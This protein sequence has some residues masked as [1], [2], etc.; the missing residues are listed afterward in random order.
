MKV[1]KLILLVSVIIIYSSWLPSAQANT[2]GDIENHWA[3]REIETV[4]KL[5]I[6][7]NYPDGAFKP[8]QLI[9]RAEFIKLLVIAG[10]IKPSDQKAQPVFKD[11]GP[12]FWA[13]SYVEA[14]VDAG[15]LTIAG[16]NERFFEPNRAITRT[17]MA[18]QVG[19]LMAA[20]QLQGVR[21][22]TDYPPISWLDV[23][24]AKGII[25]GYPD[26][27]LA[28]SRGLT[29][30]EACVVILRLKE[31]LL[32]GQAKRERQWISRMQSKDGY[33]T[34]AGGRQDVNP[35]FGNLTLVAQLGQP[36]YW[37]E[38]K[39]YLEW[40]LAHL[41]YPDNLGLNGTIYNFRLIDG[42][43]Q[44][45]NTYDSADSYA[46]T[47]LSLAAAYY[48][49]SGD[50][51]FIREHFQE[52]TT[53]S[54][55]ITTLQDT[56]GLIWVKPDTKFKYLMDN[57]ECY[58]G[59]ADWSSLLASLG[60][61]DQSELCGGKA[62]LIK[63]GILERF[64]DEDTA[65]FAWAIDDQGSK[66]LLSHGQAYPGI[67]AQIYPVTFGVTPPTS[68]KAILAYQKL[69]DE[70]PDWAELEVGDTFPW[71]ILGYAAVIMD[72]L[73]GADRFL[74]NCRSTFIN[75]DHYYPWSTFED[76]FYIRA[77]NALQKRIKADLN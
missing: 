20:E 3:E 16:N 38:V 33:I 73:S 74:K 19:R 11:V 18:A 28:G 8:D 24:R 17:E 76:A 56:D 71:A 58:R 47:L 7:G 10:W 70:L 32:E 61:K 39:R 34:M 35:Y 5:G 57:S 15:I 21:N 29:R 66:Y 25:L 44:S 1:K 52:F 22:A 67:V 9:T 2:A 45:E 46:A 75:K 42:V 55:I 64:W 27:E 43:V 37:V 65:S 69:N 6:A 12:E 4:L 26:G 48:Y 41:N 77:C 68:Q 51:N 40:T 63:K 60:F 54:E 13:Y 59:L 62:G 49:A 50:A 36:E 23:L 53:V 14:A 30:A 72:D 31:Q